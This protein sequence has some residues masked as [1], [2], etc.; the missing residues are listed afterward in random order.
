MISAMVPPGRRRPGLALLLTLLWLCP[1]GATLG[2]TGPGQTSAFDEHY[3]AAR[4]LYDRQEFTGAA[5]EFL[6]AY[7][8]RR[9]PRLLLN[10]GNA[11]LMAGQTA[12]ALRLYERCEAHRPPLSPC[13]PSAGVSCCSTCAP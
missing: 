8:I 4:R 10:A 2:R 5:G 7:E 12:D 3:R 13:P 9:D 6:A 11:L 1:C